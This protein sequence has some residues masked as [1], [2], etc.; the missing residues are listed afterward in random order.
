M[1]E[2]YIE[3]PCSNGCGNTVERKKAHS[4]LRAVCIECKRKYA[5]KKNKQYAKERNRRR[6]EKLKKKNIEGLARFEEVG[7]KRAASTKE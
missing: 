3:M 7:K 4:H 1:L 5:Q 2:G 6:R